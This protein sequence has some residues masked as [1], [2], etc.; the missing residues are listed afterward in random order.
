M[1]IFNTPKIQLSG[2]LLLIFISSAINYNSPVFLI[3][4]LTAVSSAVIFDLIFLKLRKIKLFLPSAAIAS[5]LIITLLNSPIRPLYELIL[6]CAIAMFFKNFL[7][8]SNRHI[9]NPAGIGLFLGSVIFNHSV[10]WWGVSFQNLFS[11]GTK[12]LIL[13]FILLSPALISIIK[14]KRYR[15]TL[16]FLLAYALAIFVLNRSVSLINVFFDPTVIFFSI[17]MAPE[18][19]T[20]PNRHSRQILFGI[21]LGITAIIL[22]LPLFNLHFN[23]INFIPDSLIGA[24][25]ISNLIFYKYK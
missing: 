13:Y 1:K 7:R 17:V 25:I 5:G 12:S 15:I 10:S 8:I 14:M 22:S 20:T 16:S 19:M 24:L 23:N 11:P 3:N 4:L 18:P 6:I 9:F 21:L 2:A